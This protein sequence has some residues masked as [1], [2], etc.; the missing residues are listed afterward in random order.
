MAHSCGLRAL[1]AVRLDR[2]RVLRMTDDVHS[3]R[4]LFV[5]RR[6]IRYTDGSETQQ[7]KNK[8]THKHIKEI[9]CPVCMCMCV[10]A[11]WLCCK[12]DDKVCRRRHTRRSTARMHTNGRPFDIT[13]QMETFNV[14]LFVL[15]L[16]L[17]WNQDKMG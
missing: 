8:R 2:I 17:L 15:L 6:N 12:H 4:G 1:L 10:F 13:S 3:E 11:L 5:T 7:I 14:I 16:A 9:F